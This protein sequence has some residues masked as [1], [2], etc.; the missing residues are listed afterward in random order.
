MWWFQTN[1]F[2]FHSADCCNPLLWI[3]PRIFV[4]QT[5]RFQQLYCN[6]GAFGAKLPSWISLHWWL[7]TVPLKH[8][9]I[10]G[11]LCWVGFQL[12]SGEG[13]A[14]WMH[15]MLSML[16]TDRA[17][18]FIVQPSIEILFPCIFRKVHLDT[19]SLEKLIDDC[20]FT[21]SS[22]PMRHLQGRHLHLRRIP[23]LV[24]RHTMPW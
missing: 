2:E 12:Y 17:L 6:H 24:F 7:I 8:V 23:S 1:V 5:F 13:R 20:T 14:L 21:N 16:M 4:D 11:N 10:C 3:L 15:N 18:V 22:S 19:M 9:V